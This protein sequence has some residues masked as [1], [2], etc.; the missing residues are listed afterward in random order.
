MSLKI[1]AGN[2]CSYISQKREYNNLI[3][4]TSI[5]TNSNNNIILGTPINTIQ[6]NYSQ[7]DEL[8]SNIIENNNSNLKNINKNLRNSINSTA[9]LMMKRGQKIS[10]T[11]KASNL[12]K[13]MVGMEWNA[14]ST[15]QNIIDIDT[16]I[17][18]VDINN[19]TEEHNFIFYNNPKSKCGGVLLS[20]DHNSSLK[21]AFNETIQL[22]LNLIPKSIQKLA[23]TITIDDADIKNQNFRQISNAYFTIIDPINKKEILNYK[24][25]DNLSIETA[26]VIAEIYRYKDE[27]KITTIGSG[28]RGGLQALCDNYGIETQ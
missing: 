20:G 26:L 3:I 13:L 25:N 28:F 17:F 22:N 15:T 27:W 18:M 1:N 8:N 19:K 24:F 23:I 12:S 9:S 7:Q 11:Q 6:P 14:S 21:S 5:R 10:I 16:S 2:E 4:E